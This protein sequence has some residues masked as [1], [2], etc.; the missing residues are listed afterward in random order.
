MDWREITIIR[1][2][3][4]LEPKSHNHMSWDLGVNKSGARWGCRKVDA[5]ALKSWSHGR[6]VFGSIRI[7][8]FMAPWM[9]R[10]RDNRGGCGY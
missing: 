5:S 4:P 10:A 6:T 7:S 1:S 8:V 9:L 2:H 3:W